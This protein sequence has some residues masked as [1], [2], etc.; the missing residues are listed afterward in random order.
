MPKNRRK[1]FF[2]RSINKPSRKLE[3][4]KVKKKKLKRK[5]EKTNARKDGGQISENESLKEYSNYHQRIWQESKE[6]PEQLINEV[7]DKRE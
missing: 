5:K 6:R 7:K 3:L 2:D 4:G 1:Y